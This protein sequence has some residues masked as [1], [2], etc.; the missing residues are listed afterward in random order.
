MPRTPGPARFRSVLLEGHKGAACEVP[1]DPAE[2]WGTGPVPLRRGRRGHRV[3][4]TVGGVSFE[5]AVVPR[6]RRFW[7][8]VDE[9]TARAAGV[10]VG[11]EVEVSIALTGA[12]PVPSSPARA[13]R[14]P[15][16]SP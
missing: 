11:D 7:L 9:A 3:T 10:A 4:A 6:S 16:K 1:F 12:A 5:G 15:R 14:R 8:L 13:A 2:R